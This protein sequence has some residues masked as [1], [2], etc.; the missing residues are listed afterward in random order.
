MLDKNVDI[1]KTMSGTGT[2]EGP[3]LNGIMEQLAD[4]NKKSNESLS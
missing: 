1:L 4:M 2:G 3:D